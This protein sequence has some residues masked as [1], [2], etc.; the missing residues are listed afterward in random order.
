MDSLELT[1][2]RAVAMVTAAIS[3]NQLNIREPEAIKKVIS[4]LINLLIEAEFYAIDSL[5]IK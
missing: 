3:S 2:N 5:Y 1:M 4:S